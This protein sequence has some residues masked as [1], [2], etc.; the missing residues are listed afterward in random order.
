MAKASRYKDF[1]LKR[2]ATVRRGVGWGLMLS[3]SMDSVGPWQEQKGRFISGF[4]M[5]Y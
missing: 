3:L 2:F 5:D 1:I 4:N